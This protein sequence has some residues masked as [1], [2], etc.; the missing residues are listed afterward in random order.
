MRTHLALFAVVSTAA[1]Q[2]TTTNEAI[3]K[4]TVT[5]APKPSI[6]VYTPTTTADSW[7]CATKNF[8]DYLSPPMP[9]GNLLDIYY[10][11]SDKIYK[12]CEDKL[13]KP[14]TEFPACKSMAKASWCEVSVTISTAVPS[15]GLAEFRSYTSVASSWWT[16]HSSMLADIRDECPNTWEDAKMDVPG[17]EIWLNA[18]SAFA[19]CG[20][21]EK[22]AANAQA[23]AASASA[24]ASGS[25]PATAK[26]K[27][28]RGNIV[29]SVGTRCCVCAIRGSVRSEKE[30]L[31]RQR[32]L[33]SRIFNSD[34]LLQAGRNHC[35][36]FR[37]AIGALPSAKV[38][39]SEGAGH[40]SLPGSSGV[41]SFLL[42]LK[43]PLIKSHDEAHRLRHSQI[44]Y[45]MLNLPS[46]P[47]RQF[48]ARPT[49]EYEF[50]QQLHYQE[51]SS[52]I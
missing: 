45:A 17:G 25:A 37:A 41:S 10:S 22:P 6:A 49:P 44:H 14:F 18:T 16:A 23:A 12:E 19:N 13:P 42:S 46:F 52:Y 43:V 9:T 11:H 51:V 28:G 50:T 4:A 35:S 1:A 15:S 34:L 20:G 48:N 3:G 47:N 31:R 2:I 7:E 38:P 40:L 8:T 30:G 36:Y 27:G 33:W 39:G 21:E 5:S 32:R 26:L 29:L 24:S